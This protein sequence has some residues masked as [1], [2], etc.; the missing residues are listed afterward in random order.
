MKISILTAARGVLLTNIGNLIEADGTTELRFRDLPEH[1]DFHIVV[2][3]RN[4]SGVMSQAQFVL[5][6]F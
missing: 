5:P 2:R 1:I 3:H 4:H 6:K